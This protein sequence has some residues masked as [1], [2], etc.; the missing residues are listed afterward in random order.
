MFM[1]NESTDPLFADTLRQA[2]KMGVGILAYKC[3][4]SISNVE[5]YQRVD[6]ILS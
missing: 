3:K 1:P 5:I 6:T 4:V 2:S